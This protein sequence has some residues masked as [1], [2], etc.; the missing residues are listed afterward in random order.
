MFWLLAWFSERAWHVHCMTVVCP[1][2]FNSVLEVKPPFVDR[3]RRV[4]QQNTLFC[5][6]HRTHT[7]KKEN[8]VKL[9]SVKLTKRY[10][11]TTEVKLVLL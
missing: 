4:S 6:V 11:T 8:L 3:I 9:F 2:F 5:S 10:E 7:L 1:F